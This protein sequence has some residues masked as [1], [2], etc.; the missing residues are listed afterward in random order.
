MGHHPKESATMVPSTPQR[1][2]HFLLYPQANGLV[3]KE[4][5]TVK[6]LLT[7]AKK[8]RRDPYLGLLEYRN[9]PIDDIGS[10]A[11]LLMS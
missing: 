1:S 5:Q 9:T 6:K 3:E 7:K 8:D 10:L 4:V 11:Q 2:S